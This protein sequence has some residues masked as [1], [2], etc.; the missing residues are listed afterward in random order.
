M[1]CGLCAE[2]CPFDAIK[3]D[4]DFELALYDRTEK[5]IY[6]KER[7]S[8]SVSYYSKIRPINYNKEET[9]RAEAVAAKE[10]RKAAR[11]QKTQ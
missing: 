2:Y 10:A 11:K 8:R 4:H 6:N 1:N 5:N 3:M 9:A 7:L